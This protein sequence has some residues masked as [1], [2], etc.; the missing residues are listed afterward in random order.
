[1]QIN[2]KLRLQMLVQNGVFV[3]LMLA[4]ATLLAFF[5][6]EYRTERDLTQNARNTLSQ[7]TREVLAKLGGPVKVT[8]YATRQDVR[9]DARKQVQ[10]FLTP[11]QRIK[12]DLAVTFVDPREEPKLAQAAGIRMNGESIIAYN[13]KSEHLTEYSE[14]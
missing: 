3:V 10:D 5:A 7:Q 12:A 8:V 2:P 6:R 13:E 14:Q 4:L 1:M 11:Y 9:G